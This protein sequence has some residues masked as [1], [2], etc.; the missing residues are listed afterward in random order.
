[1]TGDQFLF[2]LQ[3]DANVVAREV[4]SERILELRVHAPQS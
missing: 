3:A 2:S 1:M 4:P